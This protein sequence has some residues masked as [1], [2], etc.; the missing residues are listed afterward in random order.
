MRQD[1]AM[2]YNINEFELEEPTI[3]VPRMKSLQDLMT[4]FLSDGSDG[5]AC[6]L[7]VEVPKYFYYEGKEYILNF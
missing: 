5:H 6:N 1:N 7:N 4:D 3:E 2:Y